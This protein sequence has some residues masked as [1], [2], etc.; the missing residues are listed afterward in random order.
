MKK[1]KNF[2]KIL[3]FSFLLVFP[4]PV[5]AQL[6]VNAQQ[7]LM[8]KK[9][10]IGDTAELRCSF[11]SDLDL[12]KQMQK[13]ES[14]EFSI[15]GFMSEL[16]SKEY[17]IKKITFTNLNTNF[18]SITITFVPW[19]TGLI[20]FPAYDVDYGFCQAYSCE[21]TNNSSLIL[22]FD[23]VNIVSLTEQNSIYSPKGA[24][25]PLLLPGTTYKIY[26]IIVLCIIL[27]II[28]IEAI[29]KHKKIETF[30][31]TQKL[32]AKYRKNKKLTLKALEKI[33]KS[34]ADDKEVSSQLQ[35][36]MRNYLEVRFDYPFSKCGASEIMTGFYKATCG[37]ASEAK[38]TA[39][40]EI[41]AVFVRTDFIRYS[42]NSYG[43]TKSSFNKNEKLVVI[44]SLKNSI[45]KIE[46]PEPKA[47]EEIIPEVKNV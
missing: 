16:N 22:S 39:V 31:R 3:C 11:N 38:E 33:L 4:L 5:F 27:V 41:A 45:E 34:D 46:A 35:K 17:E 23:D 19:K 18:Y 13:N 24:L 6:S 15:T 12:F 32:L 40:E 21:N 7:I 14:K 43:K 29:L 28:L 10:Y 26:G 42:H 25:S 8:P 37:L 9:V 1:Y 2:L 20:R 36:L 44:A 47:A 30:I